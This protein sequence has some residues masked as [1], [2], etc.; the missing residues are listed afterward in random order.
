MDFL[1]DYKKRRT[2]RGYV[3]DASDMQHIIETFENKEAGKPIFLFNVTMQN[4]G[5]YTKE[6]PTFA[7]TIQ[8]DCA[9]VGPS[10]SI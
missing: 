7:N 2:L 10:I 9:T 6:Y 1:E 8:A 4:H 3:S 5:G